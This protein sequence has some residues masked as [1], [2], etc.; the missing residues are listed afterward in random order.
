[1]REG[2]DFVPAATRDEMANRTD[3]GT[4]LTPELLQPQAPGLPSSD[5]EGPTIRR[6]EW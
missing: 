6:P 3:W 2:N 4:W 5:D 1:M